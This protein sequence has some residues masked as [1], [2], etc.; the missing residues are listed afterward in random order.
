MRRKKPRV[1]WL[2]TTP[3]FST[4]TL[5]LVSW[6]FS[7]SNTLDD[8]SADGR[9]TMEVPVI[10][11]GSGSGPLS[12]IS[13]LSDIENS[14]YRLRR[15]VGKIFV[16]IGQTRITTASII[17]VTA[18]FIIRR[19]D[20]N[21]ASLA[22]AVVAD[23]VNPAT[24][25]NQMDPW[26][27]RRSWLLGNGPSFSSDGGSPTNESTA[28]IDQRTPSTNFGRDQGSALDGPHV[29]QKTARIIG[30]EE[31]LF[32]DVSATVVLPNASPPNTG[33]PSVVIV[34][35]FRVLG[36]MRT[37]SGNRRNASR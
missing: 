20:P 26:I 2:P 5:G 13:T 31:R 35:E 19:T 25:D 16:F 18:G 36:S 17:G 8:T 11:D 10:L 4:D 29:D 24:I 22:G 15:I 9:A 23:N 27:W 12:P 30:P 3:E 1:V 34:T 14:G 21:G 6:S 33:N 37:S 32:L 7:G 28:L